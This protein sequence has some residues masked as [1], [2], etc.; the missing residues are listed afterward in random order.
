MTAESCTGGLLS[1]NITSVGG[2]SDVFL[3]TLFVIQMNQ[4]K[5]FKRE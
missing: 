4:N 5:N 1:A 3:H 2:S